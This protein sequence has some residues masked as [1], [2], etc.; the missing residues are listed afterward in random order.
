MSRVERRSWLAGALT[1]TRREL[2][3]TLRDWRI[4]IPIALFQDLCII[5][6]VLLVNLLGGGTASV[7]QTT[8][9]I[10]ASLVLVA[11]LVL[12]GRVA[13]PRLLHPRR[14]PDDGAHRFH[15][16]HRLHR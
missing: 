13:V 1:V 8:L 15:D 14:R 2:R 11:G 5:P 12:G 6:L 4:V 10:A 7:W 9:T 16:S 3:D